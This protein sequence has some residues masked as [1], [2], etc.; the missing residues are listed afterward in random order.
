MK[1]LALAATLATLAT[2]PAAAQERLWDFKPGQTF[3]YELHSYYHYTVTELARSTGARDG[4][5]S[6]GGNPTTEGGKKFPPEKD[7]PP[8]Y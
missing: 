7:K 2:L 5:D 8:C 4:D 1:S 3:T 6:M